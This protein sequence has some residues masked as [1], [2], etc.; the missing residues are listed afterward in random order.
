MAY[1]IMA[2]ISMAYIRM[3]YISMGY[4][5][6]AY[7]SMAYVS[8]AYIS[9]AYIRMGNPNDQRGRRASPGHETT[10]V[11]HRIAVRIQWTTSRTTKLYKKNSRSTAIG[12]PASSWVSVLQ[13]GVTMARVAGGSSCTHGDR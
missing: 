2:Y 11:L 6:M 3:A 1:I 7:V 9:M 4:V 5:S 8:M 13:L 10:G 12:R